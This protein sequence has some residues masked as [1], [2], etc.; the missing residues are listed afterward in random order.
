MDTVSETKPLLDDSYPAR[1]AYAHGKENASGWQYGRVWR[2]A[3]AE[4]DQPVLGP[5]KGA[6]W[7]LNADFPGGADE[8]CLP[9]WSNGSVVMQI[10]HWRRESPG[11]PPADLNKLVHE[12]V[13][14]KGDPRP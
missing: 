8:R 6:G 3:K 7:V 5:P 9:R 10:T 14:W 1:L 2:F 4:D 11:M 13:T 12:R